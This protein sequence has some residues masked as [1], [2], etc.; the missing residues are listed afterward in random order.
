M[1]KKNDISRREFLKSYAVA[2]ASAAVPGGLAPAA[3][4]V[5]MT[6]SGWASSAPA[7]GDR[8]PGFLAPSGHAVSQAS[9]SL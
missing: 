1:G 6:G 8:H 9:T 4:W 7:A 3:C 5:R 2:G